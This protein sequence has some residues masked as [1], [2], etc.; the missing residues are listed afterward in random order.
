MARVSGKCPVCGETIRVN[1]EKENGHCSK[2]GAQINVSESIRLFQANPSEATSHQAEG[3]ASQRHLKREQREREAEARIQADNAKQRIHDMFQQCS[4]EQDYL[5]LRPRI[6]EMNISDSEKACLLEALDNATKERLEDT[7][8]KAKDYAES[9]ESPFSLLVGL[10]FIAGIGLAINHFFSMTWP[11]IISVS[12]SV[13]ALF[14]NISDRCNKKK[15]AENK[16]AAD[17]I[18]QYRRIGYK[19]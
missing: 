14:G 4:N 9:Q 18:A 8:K 10:I 7:L 3:A 15:V 16:A 1:D 17:L 11:G 12:L 6:M 5:S 13:L 2:C 19:I